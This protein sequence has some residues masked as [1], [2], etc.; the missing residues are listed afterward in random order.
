MRYRNL[1]KSYTDFS[2]DTNACISLF[3]RQNNALQSVGEM[4][5]SRASET[6][7][8]KITD[9]GPKKLPKFPEELENSYL[10]YNSTAIR[11]HDSLDKSSSRVM[12]QEEQTFTDIAVA[13][14]ELVD[15]FIEATRVKE[16]VEYSEIAEVTEM[17]L[18]LSSYRQSGPSIAVSTVL[19]VQTIQKTLNSESNLEPLYQDE[20]KRNMPVYSMNTDCHL[21]LPDRGIA[22]LKSASCGTPSTPQMLPV[23]DDNLSPLYSSFYAK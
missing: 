6:H 14:N 8:R 12:F 23:F 20:S 7:V 13:A 17:E 22:Y 10:H 5:T 3:E 19:D 21:R 11:S 2:D 1:M 16:N 15:N 4:L 18:W 9:S